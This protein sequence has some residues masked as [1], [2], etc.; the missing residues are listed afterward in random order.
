M[1][2]HKYPYTDLHELNLD[3]FLDKF[4][5][6][7]E[8]YTA[9]DYVG[10]QYSEHTRYYIACDSGSDDN[11]GLSASSPWQ[12]LDKLLDQVNGGLVDARC[13]FIEPG[14]YYITHQFIAN[15][16]LHLAP[17]VNGV[18]IVFDYPDAEAFYFQDCHV[19]FGRDTEPYVMNIYTP[20][21]GI[22]AEGGEMAFYY[23]NVHDKFYQFGGYINAE[24]SGF[25][26]LRLAGTF[27][28]LTDLTIFNTSPSVWAIYLLRCAAVY[29]AGNITFTELRAAGSDETSAMA[30][31]SQGS[32]LYI[33]CTRTA[34]LTN[35]YYYAIHSQGGNIWSYKGRYNAFIA[36]H[37]ASSA[38]GANRMTG[39]FITD[40]EPGYY[41]EDVS[42]EVEVI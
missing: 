23:T 42:A 18:N 24:K 19:K 7:E 4:K 14:N 22:T 25:D 13:Y 37:A 40:A 2:F 8:G 17:T 29:L 28:T 39:F 11:D 26:W 5:K 21:H 6:Y 31:V 38:V 16:V 33:N 1:A 30:H 34:D 20:G 9:P 10:G 27:G 35:K 3:W 32:N 36:D 41:G 12:T 15:V